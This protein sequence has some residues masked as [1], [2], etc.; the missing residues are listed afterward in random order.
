M[1]ITELISRLHGGEEVAGEGSIWGQR[2]DRPSG[3]RYIFSPNAGALIETQT[4]VKG[5][6]TEAGAMVLDEDG[7]IHVVASLARSG[8][9]QPE[10]RVK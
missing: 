8:P 1:T 5:D 10:L 7:L 6:W 3:K 4:G 2:Q 9:L